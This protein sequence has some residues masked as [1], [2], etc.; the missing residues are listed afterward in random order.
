M[1]RPEEREPSPGSAWPWITFAGAMGG[2]VKL[3]NLDHSG[4]GRWIAG[5]WLKRRLRIAEFEIVEAMRDGLF[6]P[7]DEEGHF[8]SPDEALKVWI[9]ECL[10]GGQL[11][12]LR[13]VDLALFPMNEV[14]A[15]EVVHGLAA[16]PS[17]TLAHQAVAPEA[18]VQAPMGATEES[19]P[20]S[21]P[22]AEALLK[23]AQGLMREYPTKA[24]AKFRIAE[25][26]K[27]YPKLPNSAYGALARGRVPSDESAEADERWYFRNRPRQ[28]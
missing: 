4:G 20:P 21:P 1:N 19:S 7:R 9:G 18:R 24:G 3:T 2:A 12:A 11:T 26:E 14:E 22:N 25:A 13:S 6:H 17:P 27:D 23:Y 28:M 15:F 5:Y 16:A 8:L 10:V